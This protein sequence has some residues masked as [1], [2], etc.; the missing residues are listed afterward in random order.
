MITREDEAEIM[1]AMKDKQVLVEIPEDDGKRSM[2]GRPLDLNEG[3]DVESEEGEVGDDEDDDGD[4]EDDDDDGDSTTDVAGSRSSSNNSNTNDA[5]EI[6]KGTGGGE[7]RVPSVR[8]YNRSKL[9]RLRW[10]PDLHMAFIHA[11]ERLGGQERATPK[12]VLQ[13]M[14]VRGLSIAHVKSHLQMYRS[15]KLDHEGRQIRGAISSVYSPMDFHSMR[16]DRRFHDMFLQRAA[17]LSSRADNGGFFASPNG[18]GTDTTSRLY[19]ILQHHH[20]PSP[21]QAFGFK[22][23]SFRNQEWAFSQHDMISRKDVKAPS[24]STTPHLF[25]SSSLTKWP[26]LTCVVAGAGELRRDETFGY[27]TASSSRPVSTA[28]PPA[29]SAVPGGGS[30]RL[31]F[32]WYGGD[33]SNTAKTTSS[34]PVVIDEALDFRLKEQKHLEPM[35][36]PIR[37]ADEVRGKR[38]PSETPD[39]KLSLS[40]ATVDTTDGASS[41]KRKITPSSEQEIEHGNKLSIALSLSPPAASMHM[42]RK[43]KTRGGSVEAALG[44]ST[45]D[46]TMSIRALE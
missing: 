37:L 46:L 34:D 20:R 19:G 45:L 7:H 43:E 26:A 42:P 29:M 24:S 21:I 6:Q 12:L 27:F 18:R 16:G 35:R 33:G 40:P 15:K 2:G 36:D 3:A 28:M 14:N 11:V 17:V 38:R 4:Q 22:N 30:H 44:Q 25:A 13:M 8:P 5:S 23:C 32:R 31:P 10:T 39:L 1:R 9:P 41:N